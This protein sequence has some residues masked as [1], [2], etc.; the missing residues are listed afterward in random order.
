MGSYERH[1]KQARTGARVSYTEER[2][3]HGKDKILYRGIITR[4]GER[5]RFGAQTKSEC[6]GK[7]AAKLAELEKEGTFATSLS[8]DEKRDAAKARAKLADGETLESA[9]SELAFVRKGMGRGRALE[10]ALAEYETARAELAGRATL[11]EAVAFW[12]KHHP[13]GSTVTLDALCEEY[14]LPENRQKGGESPTHLR[15]LRVRFA[16]LQ[17]AFGDEKPVAS[18]MPDDLKTFLDAK[19]AEGNWSPVTYNNWLRVFKGLF[20]FADRKHHVGNAAAG[21]EKRKEKAPQIRIFT[22][23]EAARLLRAAEVVAPDYAA[24]VAILLFAGVRPTELVGQ[25]GLEGKGILGGLTWDRV[26][27]D[28]EIVLEDELT[29]TNQRRT[30]PL[31]ENLAAWLARYP[32]KPHERV[33]R[34]PISWRRARA[35]I[36][37]AAGVEW[38]PD[39]AR[40]SYASY[41]FALHRN[42]DALE[43]AMGHVQGGAAVLER[44]YKKRASKADA[45]KFW[46]IMPTEKGGDE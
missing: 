1:D 25:Y 32:G 29:K 37:E 13:D 8:P 42:R 26:D 4:G 34:T 36:A 21:I 9:M 31:S 11:A 3:G 35:K 5:W 7:V 43:A 45:E 22:P 28:G 19:S 20:A 46:S 30:I 40:H 10:K 15:G 17:D 2:Y 24:A 44:H 12:K 16:A 33:V 39:Q 38:T 23:D 18:I 6:E 14:L 41:H 27:V